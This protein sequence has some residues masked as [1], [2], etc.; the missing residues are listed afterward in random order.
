MM[1]VGNICELPLDIML[2][3]IRQLSNY[4]YIRGLN[5]TCKSLSKLISKFDVVKE[6]FSVL[7][8]RF[9]SH[10]L[11]IYN[12]NRKYVTRCVN[13]YCKKETE[14]AV[15]YIWECHNGLVYNHYTHT[16]QE[17][18]NTNKMMVNGKKFWFRSPYCCECFKKHVL[19]G[20]NKNVSHH[21]G[22]YCYGIQQVVVTFNTI[23]PS[24]WYN[25]ATGRYEVLSERHLNLL[26]G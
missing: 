1:N 10:E 20:N 24:T 16:R 19:V 14:K 8:A 12:P 21:Y 18:Q 11:H 6:V 23:Q 7:F 22:N 26:N 13:E 9:N 3:I 17:P 25:C 5:I 4:E 15:V 2:L